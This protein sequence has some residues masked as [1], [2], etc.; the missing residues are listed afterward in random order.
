MTDSLFFNNDCLSAFL[1]VGNENLLVKLYPGQVRIPKQVYNELSAP[2]VAHLKAKV[3]I[4]LAN[5]Q[6]SL[7]EIAVGTEYTIN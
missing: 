4:L 5:K 2:E 3:D 1:W 7:T 6:V